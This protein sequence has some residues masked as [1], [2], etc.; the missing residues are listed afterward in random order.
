MA[1][2]QTPIRTD[3]PGS[4]QPGRQTRMHPPTQA[5]APQP[6]PGYQDFFEKRFELARSLIKRHSAQASGTS[7]TA[8]LLVIASLLLLGADLWLGLHLPPG[9]GAFFWFLRLIVLL[10][11]L[12]AWLCCLA[13]IGFALGAAAWVTNPGSAGS[14][15]FFQPGD[16]ALPDEN[17]FARLFR[18]STQ[19]QMLE[20]ALHELYRQACTRQRQ[21]RWLRYAVLFFAIALLGISLGAV[22]VFIL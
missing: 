16:A 14:D 20:S 8:L 3:P 18:E 17:Q 15:L 1:P 10:I 7:F 19:A 22:V 13:A 11:L 12:G 5:A 2:I 9:G 21:E 6:T 4:P